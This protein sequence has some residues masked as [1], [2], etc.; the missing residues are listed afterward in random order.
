MLSTWLHRD[1][2]IQIMRQDTPYID[3]FLVMSKAIIVPIVV[4]I[5]TVI[6]ALAL[7]RFLNRGLDKLN[8]G[9]LDF[10]E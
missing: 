1:T 3:I 6:S 9:E 4:P 7:Y 5:I 10:V 2:Y 8:L